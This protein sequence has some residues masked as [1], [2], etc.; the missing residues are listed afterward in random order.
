MTI[1]ELSVRRP[2][3]AT[4]MSLVILL[5]GVMSYSR[6]A[7]REY[8]NI[9][10]PVVTVETTY[11]GASAEII[12]SQVT[13]PLEDSLSGIEGIDV[14]SSISRAETSQITV[15]FRIDRDADSAASD[16]RDRVGRVRN[17][18]PDEIEEPVIAKVEADAQPIIYLAFASSRHSALEVTDYADR[19]VKDRLQNLPGVANVRIF[20]ERRISMRIWLDRTRLAAF[21]LTAQDVEAA[22][23]RQNIEIPAGRIESEAREFTVV[24]E[25]DLR[26]PLQFNEM[27]IR[28]EA[29]YPVRLRDVGR[30]EIDARDTRVSARF[31]G[32]PAVA[33]GIVKQSTANPLD[34]SRA[35]TETL[36]Q[37]T[38]SAPPG[39]TITNAYDT[40]I[41]IA[42]SI[43]NVFYTIGEAIVLVVLVIFVFLR[44]VRATLVPLVTI[45]VSLIGAFSLMLLFGFSINTLTLLAMVLAVGLVVDDAIVMLENISRYVE[46][47]VPP[48]EA[49]LRGSREIAFA[50][51]AMTITLAA[52]YAPIAFQTGRTGRLFI[53]FALT[54]AGA[55]IVSGFVALTL[56]PMMCR[57]MLRHQ[58]HHNW[59][60]RAT[61]R[62][63]EALNAGYRRVLRFTLGMRAAIVLLM[64]LVAGFAAVIFRTLPSELSP[65]EDRGTIVAIGIAPEGST[66]GF[67]ES[68]ARRME[69]IWQSV[70]QVEKYF[71]VVGFPV[72]TQAISFVRLVDWEDRTVKTQQ[73][74]P[75]LMPKLF[76]G[77]PGILAFATM[78]PSLGQSAIEKPVQFVL[79]TSS[80]YSELQ[81]AVDRM[82]AAARKNPGLAGL[83]VDLKLNKPEL[84]VTVDREKASSLGIAVD[85]I[86]RT[87]ETMLGGRQV[88]RFKQNGKQYDVVVQVAD[89]ERTNPE[90]MAEIFVRASS[91]EM[92]P[93][94]NLVT[95]VETVAPRELNHFNKLRAATI[96]ATLA[97]GYALGDALAF[98][99]AE[100]A[101]LP[102]NIV[103]DLAGSSREYRTSTGGIYV[104]FLLALAFIYLVLAA[105]FE[106]F[107][108]PFIIML[109][110]PLSMTGA[111]LALQLTGGTLSV[112]SQIGLVTLIGLI[113]KHGILIVEFANQLQ[114]RGLSK[115]EAVVEAA[116]LRLRPILMTTGAMVLGSLPL[117]LATGAGAE[118]RSQIGWVIV[119]GLTFGTLLTLFVVPTAYTLL[120]RT[121]RPTEEGAVA[122]APHPAE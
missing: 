45:P 56:S 23:R 99:Q 4:V 1:S 32:Q 2:V 92:V 38:A 13:T 60:Y 47:G 12:E 100:A 21:N 24:S 31:N 7:V 49:A 108:D 50:I 95:I 25:T 107:V 120:A 55:V 57:L 96:S 34:V 39:M 59:A 87:L 79:Q 3:L 122:P 29:G 18:L 33:L 69:A 8:P 85:T 106:S 88:T 42:R 62:G 84:R 5:L 115:T 48:F 86:G 51:V 16:V 14:M 67:T 119:G 43:D 44:S 116:V 37:I 10:E 53:E 89:V 101:K 17:Q 91:G 71:L 30:A 80:P 110:V 54:L 109:T 90:Q 26:T 77:I 76:A 72:V 74:V 105:Q 97:P 102:T 41:F 83:D 93:L 9:D 63:L 78:P 113:T 6:L 40:S 58:E 36:P 35:L 117:A 15:R 70:P 94:A 11:R 61:E 82:M 111:L 104:T 73:V 103:T 121:R 27:I 28:D 118:S 20:G 81:A 22:L 52:V 112:Y 98:L 64:L 66:L 19:F 65:V 46:Q 68:Y 75:Q 114:E